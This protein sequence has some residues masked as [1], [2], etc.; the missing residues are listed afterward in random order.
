MRGHPLAHRLD[1]MDLRAVSPLGAH[2]APEVQAGPN[3]YFAQLCFL[4]ITQECHTCAPDQA[5]PTHRSYI[6][7]R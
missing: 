7:G 5:Q 2:I 4:P 6:F 1:M 3:R